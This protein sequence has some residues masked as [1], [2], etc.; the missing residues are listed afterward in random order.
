MDDRY[1][2]TL[3]T[4]PPESF[5]NSMA[6]TSDI[7]F[8]S[9][10]NGLNNVYPTGNIPNE[11]ALLGS[12]AAFVSS[13]SD[14][15]GTSQ[16]TPLGAGSDGNVV[17]PGGAFLLAVDLPGF[18]A[19]QP[20]LFY[21]SFDSNWTGVTSAFQYAV[22]ENGQWTPGATLPAV[23]EPGNEFPS[24][25]GS[26]AVLPI[27]ESTGSIGIVAVNTA[28]GI[29]AS[30]GGPTQWSFTNS[31]LPISGTT[32][33]GS[34]AL[35]YFNGLVYLFYQDTA[36]GKLYCTTSTPNVTDSDALGWCTPYAVNGVQLTGSPT[37]TVY[38]ND[39]YVFYQGKAVPVRF[40]TLAFPVRLERGQHR[41]R[42]S[43]RE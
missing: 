42:S 25:T 23:V 4:F 21:S 1:G 28:K 17:G 15:T 5:N 16:A 3:A 7:Y 20:W 2:S 24:V 40:S 10:I 9:I 38:N 27:T 11:T 19:P 14:S 36:S 39:L 32:A 33:T 43:R 41:L 6:S 12:L 34:P 37:A 26:P 29:F 8:T 30:S 31:S 13:M 35:A 22:Y 18:S